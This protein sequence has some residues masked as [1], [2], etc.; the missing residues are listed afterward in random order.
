MPTSIGNIHR[1]IAGTSGKESTC[2]CRRCK[3][4]GFSPWVRKIPREKEMATHSS[5]LA[6]RIPW[7]EE[8]GGLQ[9]M[10][11]QRVGHDWAHTHMGAIYI[12][13]CV[14]IFMCMY[15]CV[16]IYI[17]GWGGG[18]EKR[19]W[20]STIVETLSWRRPMVS[21]T[22]GFISAYSSCPWLTCRGSLVESHFYPWSVGVH[23]HKP[24]TCPFHG[25]SVGMSKPP[26]CL[27]TPSPFIMTSLPPNSCNR[28]S[29]SYVAEMI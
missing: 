2:Q 3:R 1:Y 22:M 18:R 24:T 28:L 4:H 5:V 10:E 7:T 9:S 27:L 20:R 6:W 14:Y 21:M 12:N 13:I 15:I 26:R 23:Q 8:P 16:Y 17:Y 25:V 19:R 29:I 11:S